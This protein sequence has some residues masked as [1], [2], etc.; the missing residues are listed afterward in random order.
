[1]R[2]VGFA[3][4]ASLALLVGLTLLPRLGGPGAPTLL[5]AP[6]TPDVSGPWAAYVAPP[7]AC[8][9]GDDA[10]APPLEQQRTMLCLVNYARARRGL[11]PVA[12]AVPLAT[13]A[14]LKA[15]QIAECG[16]FDHDPC[17]TGSTAV[18]DASQYKRGAAEWGTGENLAMASAR[19]ASPR[20]IVN[21]WLESDSHRETLFGEDWREQGVALL[22]GVTLEGH[23]DIHVWVSDFGYRN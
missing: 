8:P 2:S 11:Q 22:T 18:F 15:R 4:L 20:H 5:A 17:G 10:T 23:A 1:V 12:T 13:A 6:E 9:G 7:S 21:G 19:I 3:A 16:R 14:A